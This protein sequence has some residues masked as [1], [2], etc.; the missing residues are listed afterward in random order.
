MNTEPLLSVTGL[1]THF[2]VKNRGLFSGYSEHAAVDGVDF[3][4]ASGETLGLVGE[5][6]CGKTTLARSILRLVEPTAGAVYFKGENLLTFERRRMRAMREKMQ[7]IFQDPY[8]SLNPRMTILDIVAEPLD[9]HRHLTSAERRTQVAAILDRVGLTAAM[10]HRYPHEFSGGQR[11]RIGIARAMILNPELVVA[12]EPVSA[13]DASV[14]TQVMGL[15]AELQKAFHLAYIFISHDLSLVR[16]F[17][18]RTAVMYRGRMVEIATSETL[19]ENPLHPYTQTLLA[20]T[21]VA[22]PRRR[23]RHTTTAGHSLSACNHREQDKP[24]WIAV[25]ENHSVACH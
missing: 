21:P 11:Q 12:D 22:D 4:L 7:M 24:A 23:G 19:Y 25:S 13:L 17:A 5:S 10:L 9:V 14:Q 3:H 15:L 2:R 16:H 6:G 1:T 18:H 8:A 20:A